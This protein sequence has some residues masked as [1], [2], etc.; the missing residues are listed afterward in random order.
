M[1][2]TSSGGTIIWG[3]TINQKSVCR[4]GGR[5]NFR[6]LL[7]FFQFARGVGYAFGAGLLKRRKSK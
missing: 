7:Y 4:V 1:Y 6:I 2:R 3:L 5:E